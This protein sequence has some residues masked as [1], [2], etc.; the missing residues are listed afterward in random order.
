MDALSFFALKLALT[1]ILRS[2]SVK[3]GCTR[4][5]QKKDALSLRSKFFLLFF[6]QGILFFFIRQQLEFCKKNSIKK[7]FFSFS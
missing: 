2:R 6:S 7:T 1:E 3:I 4:A 5:Q